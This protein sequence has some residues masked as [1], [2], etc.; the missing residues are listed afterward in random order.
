MGSACALSTLS[1]QLDGPGPMRTLLGTWIGLV[2]TGGA[3][4]SRESFLS[5]QTNGPQAGRD[6]VEDEA[7]AW[8]SGRSL[9]IALEVA[10]LEL[11]SY[12][13]YSYLDIYS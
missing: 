7:V 6:F 13:G 2:R 1:S 9:D 12:N 3:A 10:M 8:Q 5:C 4:T 11:V